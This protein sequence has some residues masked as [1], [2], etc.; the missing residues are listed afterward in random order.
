M[1]TQANN[2]QIIMGTGDAAPIKP[3]ELPKITGSIAQVAAAKTQADAASSA[4]AYKSLGAGQKGSGRRTKRRRMRGGATQVQPVNVPSAGSIPG[5]NPT[6]VGKSMVQA[7]A[8]VKTSGAYDSLTKAPPMEV[9]KGGF[10]LRAAEDLYPG[11]DTELHTKRKPKTKKKH[12]R[13][14]R[15]THRRKRS[16]HSSV[17]RRRSHRV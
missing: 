14:H 7:L 8:Q 9:K 1:P 17:R 2:G 12:G 10:V 3:M 13:S 11:A 5:I 16:K 4:A 15:R 6:S